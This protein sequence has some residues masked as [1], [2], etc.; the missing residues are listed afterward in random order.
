MKNNKVKRFL[1]IISGI[2]LIL[3]MVLAVHIYLVTR[4]KQVDK[5]TISMAR[6]DIKN[7]LDSQDSAKI[8]T[9]LYSQQGVNHVLVNPHS[10]IAVFT[11]YP[12]KAS[13]D[14]IAINFRASSGYDAVRY[15]PTKEELEKGCPILP[16][17]ITHRITSFLNK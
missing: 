6:F 17:D 3:C 12:S 10:Q 7:K 9:W 11:Y 4:P 14:Q 2:F 5:Q 16:D 8:L 13:P 15:L 1:V